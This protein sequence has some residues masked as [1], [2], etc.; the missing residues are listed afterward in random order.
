MIA[1]PE[2]NWSPFLVAPLGERGDLPRSLS[3][4][5]GIGDRLRSAAFAEIQAR[6]AFLWAAEKFKE[7][8]PAGL[9]EAWTDLAAEEDKHMNW[10]LKRMQELGIAVEERKVSLHLWVSLTAC[11]SAREFAFYMASAEQ[12]GRTAGLRF[13]KDLLEKDP[14][15]AQIFGKIAEEEVT[16][17]ELT[18]RFFVA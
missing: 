3:T 14:V 2:R 9:I 18:Q 11:Q 17:I 10:L 6:E 13:Y 8:A 1:T 16:H 12:R 15:T 7:D 4:F 5:E